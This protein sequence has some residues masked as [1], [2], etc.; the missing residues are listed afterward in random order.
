MPY[1]PALITRLL[2]RMTASELGRVVP[3]DFQRWP[4]AKV[5]AKGAVI[6]E[7]INNERASRRRA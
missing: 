3:A 2:R 4:V 1:E 7:I 6:Q 5:V